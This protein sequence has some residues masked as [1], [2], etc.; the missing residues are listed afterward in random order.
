MFINSFLYF[1]FSYFKFFFYVGGPREGR[2]VDALKNG[3][4]IVGA[5]GAGGDWDSIY[6]NDQSDKVR[7]PVKS[8]LMFKL[9]T[10]VRKLYYFPSFSFSFFFFLINIITFYL[11]LS[12]QL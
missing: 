12:N 1:I 7:D 8:D 4:N 2:G 6:E 10:K 11:Y 3:G 9:S 5:G